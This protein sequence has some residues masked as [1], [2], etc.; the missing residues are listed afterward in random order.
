MPG[1]FLRWF[2]TSMCGPAAVHGQRCSGD[3][4][5]GIT[6][7]KHRE[8]A[9]LFDC[10]KALVRLL[11]EQHIPNDLLARDAVRFGLAINLRFDQRRVDITWAD[12]IAGDVGFGCSPTR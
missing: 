5:P 8:S 9:E 4:C 10:G 1:A 11:G 7:E 6:C 2:C 12:C 3:R